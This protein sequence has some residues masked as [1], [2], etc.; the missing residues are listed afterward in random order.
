MVNKVLLL[1][2]M[3]H[4]SLYSQGESAFVK[5]GTIKAIATLSLSKIFSNNLS[6][7]YLH[8]N[9]EYYLDEKISVSGEGYYFLGD[10][11]REKSV[12]NL[13]HSLFFGTNFHFIKNNNDFYIGFQPGIVVSELKMF[14]SKTFVNPLI[15]VNVGYNFYVNRYFNFFI[16]VKNTYGE[17]ILIIPFNISDVRFSAGLGFHI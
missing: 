3:L 9:L 7:F 17:N 16:L 13:H 1:F 11:S 2:L 8:G 6:P 12:F 10:L 15:S 14:T 5:K 4:F